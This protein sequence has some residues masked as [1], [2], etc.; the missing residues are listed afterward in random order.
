MSGTGGGSAAAG[1]G[2]AAAGGGTAAAGG[3]T[4]AAG[5]GTA[6]AG[7]GTAATG[8]GTAA[9]GGG[10]AATGGGTAA[11]GGGTAATGG[12]TAA[13]GG[14]TA[15]TGGGAGG[16]GTA[17]AC[18]SSLTATNVA[19]LGSG[20]GIMSD[21]AHM[22]TIPLADLTAGV[23]VTYTHGVT[24]AHTH[25]FSLTVG[26]ITMLKDGLSVTKST[27]NVTT[28]PSDNTTHS[29]SVKLTCA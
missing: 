10:T 23:A 5:G 8:G 14:G 12:G 3:G 6:A 20:N 19:A 18:T 28:A 25:T 1:G 13:T 21:H 17:D 7:G 15:A 9:T 11:T 24:G 4:A 2:T 22:L 27:T 29:H 26:E 16:G